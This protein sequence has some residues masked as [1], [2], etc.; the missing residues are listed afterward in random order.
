MYKY[1]KKNPFKIVFFYKICHAEYV[2]IKISLSPQHLWSE[3]KHIDKC[4][5]LL[6][7]DVLWLL[8]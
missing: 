4:Y 2:A 5:N 3:F 6:L 1:L 7:Y 8:L